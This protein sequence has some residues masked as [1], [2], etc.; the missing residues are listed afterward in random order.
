MEVSLEGA[1]E[2][3]RGSPFGDLWAVILKSLIPQGSREA[4]L[5]RHPLQIICIGFSNKKAARG[6]QLG[7]P[8]G[9]PVGWGFL[10]LRARGLQMGS[11]FWVP[12]RPLN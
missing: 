6:S 2:S 9:T 1:R 4:A 8:L 10:V 5:R 12:W 7:R 11:P 3:K